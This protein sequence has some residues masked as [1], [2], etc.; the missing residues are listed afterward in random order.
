[1]TRDIEEESVM[2]WQRNRIQTTKGS[3]TKEYFPNVEDRL[4]MKINI[5]HNLAAI[6]TG[7]GKTKSYLHRFKII[8]EPTRPCGTAEQTTEH[9]IYNCEK[10]TKEREKLTKTALQ[11]GSWTSK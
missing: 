10:L 1:M 3:I 6:L 2:E 11:K 5:T 7:H 8:K 4:N 9:L